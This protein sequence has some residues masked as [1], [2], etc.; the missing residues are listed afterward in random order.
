M[1]DALA[2][3]DS[4]RH[5]PDYYDFG[6]VM[7]MDPR[8][9]RISLRRNKREPNEAR[10]LLPLEL[11]QRANVVVNLTTGTYIKNR[12]EEPH[13]SAGTHVPETLCEMFWAVESTQF[14]PV[15]SRNV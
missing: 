7:A 9:Y 4:L 15:Q 12:W 8:L 5:H 3:L 10:Y 1:T 6:I 11:V 14:L 2:M 13:T